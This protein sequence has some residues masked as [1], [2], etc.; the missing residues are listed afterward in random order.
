MASLNTGLVSPLFTAVFFLLIFLP[1][2]SRYTL[3]KGSARRAGE[4]SVTRVPSHV[5][6]VGG[7]CVLTGFHSH[8]AR[9]INQD[10][11][12]HGAPLTCSHLPIAPHEVLGFDHH[13]REPLS[14]GQV[15][16][17]EQDLPH[18]VHGLW[19]TIP[20]SYPAV[21][22]HHKFLSAEQLS[23]HS[24]PVLQHKSCLPPQVTIKHIA[25]SGCRCTLRYQL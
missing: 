4:G 9:G 23:G 6:K 14:R 13:H 5:E 22:Q 1:S 7:L 2:C 24:P 18:R 3:T 25:S 19:D 17:G 8:V 16:Q 20:C 15:A 10:K 21:H 11:S 12:H